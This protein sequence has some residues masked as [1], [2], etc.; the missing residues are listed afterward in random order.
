MEP[1]SGAVMVSIRGQPWER[2]TPREVEIAFWAAHADLEHHAGWIPMQNSR[3]VV[4]IVG[5]RQ[6]V[7]FVNLNGSWYMQY[8][9]DDNLFPLKILGPP[10]KPVSLS[11][12]ESQALQRF[13]VNID[14]AKHLQG[15][16]AMPGVG[17]SL[18]FEI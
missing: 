18:S 9:Y 15:A 16:R 7:M 12:K 5:D 10:G 14:I 6:K 2:L 17:D 13:N 8:H 4:T 11:K 3:S 1:T